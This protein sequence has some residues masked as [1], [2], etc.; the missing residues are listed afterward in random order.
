MNEK[1]KKNDPQEESTPQG[2][3]VDTAPPISEDE[4]I[5]RIGDKDTSRI[6]E[7]LLRGKKVASVYI[8]ARS[9]GN[10]F[11]GEAHIT[12]D[13]VGRRQTK[14]AT[15]IISESYTEVVAGQ[16]LIE[17][18]QKVN[19]VYVK[20]PLYASARE[21]LSQGHMLILWGQAH[22]GKWTTALQLLTDLNTQRILE[23]KPDIEFEALYS[24]ETETKRGYII[25]TL[26]P[27]SA[28]AINTY[29]LNRISRNFK[30][31]NSYLII[32]I[33]NRVQLPKTTLGNSLV[34]W[35]RLPDYMRV[36][37]KHLSWYLIDKEQINRVL[38]LS[39]SQ[40]VKQ[41]LDNK[42]ISP[43]E[44]D[45]LAELL[46]KVVRSELDL[47]DA[48]ARFEARALQ[49]IESWFETHTE[50][51]KR[52]FMISLA[53]LNGASYQSVIKADE[54]LQSLITSKLSEGEN[55]SNNDLFG[56][57]R[58][59]RVKEILA[60]FEQGFEE[61]EFGRSPVELLFF[62][63]PTFQ[64][65]IL[66][67]IWR[68]YDRLRKFLVDWLKDLIFN[69]NYNVRARVAAAVGELSKYNFGYI[70]E[71]ILFPWANHQNV[72]ARAAAAFA[73]GIPVWEGEFAPQVLGLLHHWSTLRNNW[74]LSW[75]AAAAYGGLVG[76]RYPDTALRDLYNIAKAED[77]R[78]FGVLNR[79]I[80]NLFSS[81]QLAGEYYEKVL[82]ALKEWISNSK[83]K[84]ISLTS[85]LIFL[86]IASTAK[87]EG[88][89]DVEE[90]PAILY[91]VDE[92]LETQ[93]NDRIYFH[94]IVT[95][96]RH[97]LN[98]KA[99]RKSALETIR[100][101][102]KTTDDD[103]RLYPAMRAIILEIVKQGASRE[104]ERLNFYLNRWASDPKESSHSAERL[105]NTLS[106]HA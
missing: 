73:L 94:N 1:D 91:L 103:E 43:G 25:D 28:E 72:H 60:H 50:L 23:I 80:I 47:D 84:I 79:S 31:K 99:S 46:I 41:L 36:L 61:T 70:K 45:R 63:N 71:E 68:E 21:I 33:D 92:E 51:E 20:P 19:S 49:K 3:P 42:I 54:N 82:T 17:D 58:S 6:V 38:E 98:T 34:V 86:N 8:D 88:I 53:I 62:D 52:T 2:P 102:L 87:S 32:T 44:L 64:P 66:Q 97:A 83:S 105:L 4:L 65:A 69:A 55:A 5:K 96:W 78:L 40:D 59:Q 90:W 29:G 85:A 12:G 24:I 13:A 37:E 27:E 81:G 76:L 22:W 11:G 35:D 7:E 74:R 14:H 100:Q 89:P 48:L 95:L 39:R 15:R 16:I 75:T 18:L 106:S 9:G 67:H 101:L 77:L 104:K 30:S 57:T 10:F 56:V 93:I 26:A